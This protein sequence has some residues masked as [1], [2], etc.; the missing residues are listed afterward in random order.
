M[1]AKRRLRI[2]HLKYAMLFPACL[3][4]EHNGRALFFEDPEEVINWLERRVA[5]ES[6]D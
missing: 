6:A 5:P 2:K 3:R 4:V 1:E